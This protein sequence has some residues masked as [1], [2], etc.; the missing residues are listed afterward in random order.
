LPIHT[1]DWSA[2]IRFNYRRVR[3]HENLIALFL[4][5][6]NNTHVIVPISSYY[7]KKEPWTRA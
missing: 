6:Y 7:E 5:V 1:L 3:P 2:V 4:E